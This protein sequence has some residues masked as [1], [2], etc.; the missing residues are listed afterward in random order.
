MVFGFNLAEK[1]SK[2]VSA[3]YSRYV[4]KPIQLIWAIHLKKYLRIDLKNF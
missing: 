4:D 3:T 2:N 1:S